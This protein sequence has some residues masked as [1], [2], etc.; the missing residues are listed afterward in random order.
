MQV[1]YFCFLLQ[2]WTLK[3]HEFNFSLQFFHH[4]KLRH[5]ESIPFSSLD[6]NGSIQMLLFAPRDLELVNYHD[7]STAFIKRLLQIYFIP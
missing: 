7:T 6:M 1:L 2:I 3:T 5:T 4:R